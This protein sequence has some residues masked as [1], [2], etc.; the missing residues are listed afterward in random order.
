MAR[1]SAV[2]KQ[3]RRERLVQLKREKRQ[4]LKA[5]IL[6][7]TKSDEERALAVRNLNKMPK[8]SSKVR[9]RN[10]CRL[11]GRSRGYLRKFQLSRLCFREM[12]SKGLIPGIMKASW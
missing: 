9:L 6:D 4:A 1:T 8:N 3:K 11:T 5:I 7:M 12:A 2:V 10:R